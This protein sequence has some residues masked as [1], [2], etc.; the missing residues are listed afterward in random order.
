[1]ATLSDSLPYIIDLISS[2]SILS[3]L[4][5]WLSTLDLFHLG[6]TNRSAHSYILSSPAVFKCLMRQC[7]C[8]GRGLAIRQTTDELPPDRG[9]LI[10]I[11]QRNLQIHGDEEIEVRLYNV[12]CDVTGALPCVKCGINICEEC[13]IRPRAAPSVFSQNRRPHLNSIWQI[14]NIYCLCPTCDASTEKELADK[15][16]N[17]LCDCDRYTRWIC[18]KCKKEEDAFTKDYFDKH[19]LME[20]DWDPE[21]FARDDARASRDVLY[22][23][24]PPGPSMIIVDYKSCRAVCLVHS[25]LDA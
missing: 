19:T 3:A 8:D 22:D 14:D 16:L 7:L 17:E 10:R 21:W 25:I 20:W 15:F 2:Y 9:Q 23:D 18:L 12:K 13:R 24:E 1:M 11:T 6:L 5:P 4:A